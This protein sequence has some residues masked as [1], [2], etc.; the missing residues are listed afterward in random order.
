MFIFMHVKKT[1]FTEA[2]VESVISCCRKIHFKKIT[3]LNI[4][5]QF[6]IERDVYS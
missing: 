2:S 6:N 4:K 5:L 3:L 1:S